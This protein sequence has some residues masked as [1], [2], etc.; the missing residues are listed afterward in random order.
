LLVELRSRHPGI[1]VRVEVN[2]A[3]YLAQH[4]RNEDLDFYLADVRN[5]VAAA[6]LTVQRVGQ[7]G[8]GFYVRA[9][10]PLLDTATVLPTMLLPH[11]IASVRVPAPVL[12]AMGQ[13]MGMA[14]PQ[15]FEP[16][17]ECDDL[18]MLKALALQTDTVIACADAAAALEVAQGTLVRLA[19]VGAPPMFADLALVSL[20]GRSFSL[21][22]DFARQFIVQAL[23][24]R[25]L[26]AH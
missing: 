7:I 23:Q 4:L 15:S 5:V 12:L 8:A 25:P 16:V 18:T 2:N 11:G 1:H 21:I 20:K 6:D 17:V 14:D 24:A 3:D 26:P 13:L 9:G 10:H 22:A 19:P